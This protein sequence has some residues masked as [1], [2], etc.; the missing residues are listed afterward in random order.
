MKIFLDSNIV[1]HAATT[2]RTQNIYFDGAKP[3]EPLVRGGPIETH[4]KSPTKNETLR[5]EIN[6]LPELARKLRNIRADLVMAHENLSEVTRAGRF[7]KEYFHGSK[8]RY[9]DRAPEYN[10][11]IGMPD[12]LNMG[13]TANHFHNFLYYLKHPRFLELAKYAGALQG[14]KPNYNQLADAYFLWCA[15]SNEADYFLTLDFKLKR[16]IDQSKNLHFN[17]RV[18]TATELLG[19]LRQMPNQALQWMP[20]APQII[21]PFATL[22]LWL[23]NLLRSGHR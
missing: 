18:V 6:C 16:S 13:P 17:P 4:H 2:Y 11:I 3:G 21:S 12:W 8:I 14:E 15:E 19:E 23:K 1:Q 9:A 20:Y 7:R 22:I 10:T 5:R